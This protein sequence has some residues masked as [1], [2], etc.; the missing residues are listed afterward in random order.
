[1]LIDVLSCVALTC[2]IVHS[3]IFRKPRE[4]LAKIHPT[5]G[6]WISCPMCFGFWVGIAYGYWVDSNIVTL[7]LLSSLCS[8]TVY[9]LVTAFD[10]LGN[11]YT[12]VIQNGDS[13]DE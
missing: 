8:W 7:G 5:I 2:I 1:M 11:Y 13:N 4:W 12:A 10:A 3:E 6:Y 9:N